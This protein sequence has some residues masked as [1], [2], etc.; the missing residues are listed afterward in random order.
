MGRGNVG[1]GQWGKTAHHSGSNQYGQVCVCVGGA[2]NPPWLFISQTLEY[3]T[4][5]NTLDCE[6]YKPV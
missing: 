5:H 1:K 3:L 4:L 6:S 2:S